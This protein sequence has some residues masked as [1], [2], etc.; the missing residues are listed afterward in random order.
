LGKVEIVIKGEHHYTASAFD[1]PLG[2]IR[3][4]EHS[5]QTLEERLQKQRDELADCAKKQKDFEA[6]VGESFEHE[7]KLHTLAQRQA[8]LEKALDITKNQAPDSLAADGVGES[9]QVST[10]VEAQ[11]IVQTPAN[12]MAT[13]CAP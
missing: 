6:K 12:K 8:D 11:K 4:L 3:S 7:A 13:N 2:T 10:A 5:M 1:S 9:E